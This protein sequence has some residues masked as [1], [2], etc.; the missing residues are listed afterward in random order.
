MTRIADRLAF[1]ILFAAVV[2]CQKEAPDDASNV[3]KSVEATEGPVAVQI[4]TEYNDHFT[5]YGGGWTGGDGAYSTP[6]PDGRVLWTFGDSFLG[7]VNPDR[8]RPPTPLIQN[9]FV[10]QDGDEF[11]TLHGGTPDDPEPYVAP[12][13]GHGWYWP[14]AMQAIGSKVYMFLL[15]F[16]ST[17][18]GGAFGFNYLGTDLGVFNLPDLEL[19]SIS[20]AWGNPNVLFGASIFDH[21]GYIYIYSTRSA[22]FGKNCLAARV[23]PSAPDAPEF[24]DGTSWSE[25]YV[26]NAFL[27]QNDGEPVKVSNMFSVFKFRNKFW[28]ITHQDVLGSEIY[29]QRGDSP[30]GPWGSRI[31]IYDTPETGGDIWTYNTII[32]PHIRQSGK[33][34]LLSYSVNSLNFGDIFADADNY[35]PKFLWIRPAANDD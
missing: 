19:E 5:R 28:L 24:W 32:H 11:T 34:V 14:A 26:P 30:T 33:G 12:P 13:G 31:T 7:T 20:P 25:S 10:I 6:L 17:G 35:R 8:S 4:A 22:G 1:L 3:P 2:G 23:L 16:E 29:L 21:E 18:E 9:T 27:L 15:H